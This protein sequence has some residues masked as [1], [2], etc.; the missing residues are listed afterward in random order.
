MEQ[1]IHFK[2]QFSV[3][4]SKDQGILIE[5]LATRHDVFF[6]KSHDQPLNCHSEQVQNLIKAANVK[7]VK[8]VTI[9]IAAFSFE[10]IRNDKIT[11]RG[12]ELN[13]VNKRIFKLCDVRINN[14]FGSLK[15][16]M[17][18]AADKSRKIAEKNAQITETMETAEILFQNQRAKRIHEMF[19]ELARQSSQGAQGGSHNV[20]LDMDRNCSE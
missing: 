20:E 18:M 8:S 6:F 10:Y 14:E 13:S 3:R 2:V 7:R 1:P 15:R 5:S 16:K 17:V 12:K 19:G 9:D 11:F 4:N